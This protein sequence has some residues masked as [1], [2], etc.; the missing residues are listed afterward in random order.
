M[1]AS[2]DTDPP[3]RRR[4]GTARAV[5]QTLAGLTATAFGR[6]GFAAGD[7]VRHWPE[8]AGTLLARHTLP[9]RITYPRG[10]RTDGIL[11]L[12]V[13]SAPVATEVQHLSPLIIEKVNTYFG[14][15]AVK[16]LHI[17]QRPLPPAAP[18][19]PAPRPLSAAERA[20]LDAEIA[21]VKDPELRQ[22]LANL[23][24]AVRRRRSKGA[25]DGG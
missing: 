23:G 3:R 11:H 18:T 14:Y 21:A 2:D 4:Q 17:Y 19:R 15:G 9:D 20:A 24:A 1:A 6:R 25:P 7:V 5:G 10:Q 12:Q 8:I 13:G 22:A 16:G